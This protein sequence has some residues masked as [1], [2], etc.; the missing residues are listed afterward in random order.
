MKTLGALLLAVSL[1]VLPLDAQGSKTIHFD[2][3]VSDVA[4][5]QST[6]EL[7]TAKLISY[8]TKRGVAVV[9][10]DDADAVLTG[11]CRIESVAQNGQTRYRVQ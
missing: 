1:P 5:N 8:L 10:G 7:V 9:E 11:S 2:Q 4:N 3:L 6:A